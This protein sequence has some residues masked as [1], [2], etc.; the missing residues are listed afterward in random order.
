MRDNDVPQEG[1]ITLGGHRKAVYARGADGKLHIVPSAGWEAE[2]IVTRQAVDSFTQLAEEA[3]Q[4]ALSGQL[5]PLVYHMY[6]ARMDIALLS[7]I[8]GLW[9]WRIRRHQHPKRFQTLSP[10]LLKR[11]ADALGI[12]VAQLSQIK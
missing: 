2:E 1:N 9:Q 12:S 10:T 4:Q 6:R 5:S 8:S 3:R 7:Q 11:Y